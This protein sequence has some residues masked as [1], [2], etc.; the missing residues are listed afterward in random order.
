MA[1]YEML[2]ILEDESIFSAV[3]K[4]Y[5]RC[6]A[7]LILSW[8]LYD[9]SDLILA[10]ETLREGIEMALSVRDLGGEALYLYEILETWLREWGRLQEADEVRALHS[11]LVD[12]LCPEDDIFIT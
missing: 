11:K 9:R 10:E 5:Y 3:G 6:R 7:L 2:N 8:C 1:V 4:L 12:D